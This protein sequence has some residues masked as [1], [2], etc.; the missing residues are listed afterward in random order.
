LEVR[1]LPK[2]F[3]HTI[4]SL[5]KNSRI[6]TPD[7]L[8]KV[9][10]LYCTTEKAQ[11]AVL[12]QLN[13]NDSADADIDC[14]KGCHY[15][16]GRIV[17]PTMPELYII[18][19]HITAQYSCVEIKALIQKLQTHSK[20]ANEAKSVQERIKV[21]CAFL[22]NKVCTIQEVKPLSCRGYASIDVAKCKESVFDP[23]V[24]VPISICHYS[25]YQIT[26]KGIMKSMYIA[27]FTD[28]T[29]ELNRGIL[30]LLEEDL[31]EQ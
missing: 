17:T 24:D 20:K 18:F 25:P 22:K 13:H 6:F 16:C 3:Q 8:Q 19:E 29:E 1:L 15:C 4:T 2:I 31:N 23:S 27:G 14:Q 5:L 26:R 10:E 12:G 30:R 11:E 28:V 7:F 9:K 21:Y